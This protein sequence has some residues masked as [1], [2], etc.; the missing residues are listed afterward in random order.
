MLILYDYD[1]A[2][3]ASFRVNYYGQTGGG[4]IGHSTTCSGKQKKLKI[5]FKF[6]KLLQKN[7]ISNVTLK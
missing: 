7:C 2:M 1:I 5:Q 4:L 6:V 3:F